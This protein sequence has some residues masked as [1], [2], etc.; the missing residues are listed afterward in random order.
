[1]EAILPRGVRS[2]H[3]PEHSLQDEWEFVRQKMR[4]WALQPERRVCEKFIV[5]VMML[6]EEHCR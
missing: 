3:R 1:M 6:C 2:L 4:R 5:C